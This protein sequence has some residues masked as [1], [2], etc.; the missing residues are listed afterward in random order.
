MRG[1][2]IIYTENKYN[3]NSLKT[4]DVIEN[5]KFIIYKNFNGKFEKE[6]VFKE[7]KDLI[8][9]I[10]GVI[11][12]NKELQK[13]YK[14]RDNFTLIEEMY[15]KKGIEFIDDLCGNFYG[16]VYDKVRMSYIHLPTILVI[17]SFT[18]ILIRKRNLY[19]K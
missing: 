2:T 8:A 14:V 17:T 5:D 6:K 15:S 4:N 12:N 11:L 3:K 19:C 1:T 7:S 18:I 16:M 9:V 10:D 13:N